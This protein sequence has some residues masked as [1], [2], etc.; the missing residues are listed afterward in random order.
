[1]EQEIIAAERT[2]EEQKDGIEKVLELNDADRRN[3]TFYN[4][5]FRQKWMPFYIGA[6]LLFSVAVLVCELTGIYKVPTL[7]ILCAAGLLGL[8]VLF[9]VSIILTTKGGITKRTL[10]ISKAGITTS[11]G[12]DNK[13][14]SFSW[15]DIYFLGKTKRYF[16]IYIDAAQFIIVPKRFYSNEEIA[17]I[18]KFF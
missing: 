10:I 12:R 11:A 15:K 7:L 9:I 6:F 17:Y 18:K 16:Y 5:F 13:M 2:A 1:M 4:V 3:A 14:L 8:L